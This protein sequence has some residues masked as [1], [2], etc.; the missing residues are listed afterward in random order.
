MGL[1]SPTES[2]KL[3]R[4]RAPYAPE[5]AWTRLAPP[6]RF[7]APSASPRSEQRHR[8]PGLPRPTACT[9]RFS[10]PPGAS[11]R[12]EPAGLVSCRIRS[13]GCALQSFAPPAQPYAVSG[14]ATLLSFGRPRRPPRPPGSA[15]PEGPPNPDGLME[16]PRERPRLQGF[17][18]HG[19]PPLTAGGL[20]RSR[21]RGS[22]GLPP[23]RVF[24]LAGTARPSPRLPSWTW[25]DGRERPPSLSFRVSVPARSARLS[26]DR[27]TL[28]GFPAS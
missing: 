1:C 8:W 26:R 25:L 27:L 19:S 18:P 15:G 12:P 14:A 2:T 10:Q 23:S 22:P 24:S 9:F 21:A 16:R 28:L 5:R 17:A 11:I 3:E 20:G 4:P 6:M 13:W 7:F